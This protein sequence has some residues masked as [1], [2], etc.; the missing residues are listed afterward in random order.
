MP[1][2]QYV[3]G[4]EHAA[5]TGFNADLDDPFR[6]RSEQSVREPFAGLFTQGM[7]THETYRRQSGDWLEPSQVEV[8][9]E[10]NSRRAR[11]IETGEPVVIGDV[12]KMSKSKYNTV[13]PEEIFDVYGVDAA[14]LFVLRQPPGARRPV[15]HRRRR[16]GLALR[17]PRLD[18]FDAQPPGGHRP[19]IALMTARA[20]RAAAR[21]HRTIKAVTEAIDDLPLQLRHRPAYEP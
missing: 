11:M 18:E 10:G 5:C 4:V 3:G 12:E 8:V 17:Q 1:V 7:V 13:A 6:L 21:H 9:A 16:R 15:V 19:P 14:R 2:D 20:G